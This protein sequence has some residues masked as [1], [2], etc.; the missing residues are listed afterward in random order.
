MSSGTDDL[1]SWADH[2]PE[3]ETVRP[4]PSRAVVHYQRLRQ[5]ALAFLAAREPDALAVN[6]P[7]RFRNYKV[8]AAAFWRRQTGRNR[9]VEET[10]VVQV[11]DR[12]D[13]CFA[14]CADRQKLVDAIHSLRE[15]REK[16]EAE[17]RETEPHL[18][19]TDCLFAEYRTWR[20]RESENPAYRK[21]CRKLD[22]L[23]RT[24]YRGSRLERVRRAE[25]ADRLYLAV[26]AHVMDPD[27]LG[28]EWGLIYVYP[29]GR[30][31]LIREA[32]KLPCSAEAR[33]HLALNIA[34]AA[35]ANVLFS[36]GVSGSRRYYRCTRLPKRR[37]K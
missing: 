33:A 5:A 25:C 2:L 26:P 21:L 22:A 13:R 20:Y 10:A 17:I 12:H 19:D 7:P 24:L 31:E 18:A 28:E 32:E 11:F 16:L 8:A 6:V 36:N 27:E 4:V 37:R 15:E 1:F 30:T 35:K 23:L 34:S 3:E 9:L 14:E 29:D